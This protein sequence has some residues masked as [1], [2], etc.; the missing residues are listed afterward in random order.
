MKDV[1]YTQIHYNAANKQL[2]KL[3]RETVMC[4]ESQMNLPAYV[5]GQQMSIGKS[6]ISDRWS[7]S[8]G[9]VFW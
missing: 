9:P 8:P 6:F 7:D 2:F 1:K 3:C 5:E 4:K